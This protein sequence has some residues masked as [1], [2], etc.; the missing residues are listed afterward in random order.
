M[1]NKVSKFNK[2]SGKKPMPIY[3]RLLDTGS[4]LGEL[5]K[6][7]LKSSDYGTGEFAVTDD[8]KMEYG[9]VLYCL[10]S[11][12]EEANLNAEECLDEALAKYQKRIDKKKDL[13]SGN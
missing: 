11:L 2:K 1:Q 13:G 9:D 7:Y 12:A 3:A 6:E 4:E 5:Y 10:L 8:F